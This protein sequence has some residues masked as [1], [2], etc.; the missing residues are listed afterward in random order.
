MYVDCAL[1]FDIQVRKWNQIIAE[2]YVAVFGFHKLTT[3]LL[4]DGDCFDLTE[5]IYKA[6]T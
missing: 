4:F 5:G 1:L 2:T 6:F 3:R